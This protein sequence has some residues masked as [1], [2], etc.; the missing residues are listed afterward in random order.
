MT[1][2]YLDVCCL[3]RPFDDQGQD[4]IRL[5]SEAILLIL[6][7]F[8]TG[9]WSWVGG[10]VMDFEVEQTSDPDRRLR[11]QLLMRSVARTMVVEAPVIAR[12]QE[13]E[14]LGFHSFDAL[15]VA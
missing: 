11:V 8:E 5:E 2:V 14:A 9:E 13:L 7:R 6:A 3:N 10:E 12:A 15:H 1:N 4:R